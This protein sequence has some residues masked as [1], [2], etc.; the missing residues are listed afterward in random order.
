[1]KNSKDQFGTD[2]KKTGGRG[3]LQKPSALKKKGSAWTISN[4]L[5]KTSRGSSPHEDSGC[6][7]TH[8]CLNAMS[9]PDNEKSKAK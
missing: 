2:K 7:R 1:M 9:S 5:I 4:W 3:R 6:D 8:W